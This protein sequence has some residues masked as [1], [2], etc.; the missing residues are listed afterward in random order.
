MQKI[1]ITFLLL[2]G[3]IGSALAAGTEI[4]LD[5]SKQRAYLVQNGDIVDSSPI[6]SG[7]ANHPTPTGSFRVME[8]DPDHRSTMY[9]KVVNSKGRVVKSDADSDTPVPRGG[10]F[11]QAPMR[12]FLRFRGPIGMHAGNLPGY[13]ASHGCVRLPA[14]KAATFYRAASIGTPVK[15]YGRAP[16]RRGRA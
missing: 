8:K 9:G 14:G 10:K 5:L 16:Y 1:A 7:R 11:V 12:N 3:L 13:P 4:R 15:V 6:A 2:L